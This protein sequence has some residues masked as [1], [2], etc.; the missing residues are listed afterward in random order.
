[1]KES[2]LFELAKEMDID[3]SN[4]PVEKDWRDKSK[5]VPI[6]HSIKSSSK[7]KKSKTHV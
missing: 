1:M 6:I 2:K 4:I 7:C 3:I 5:K